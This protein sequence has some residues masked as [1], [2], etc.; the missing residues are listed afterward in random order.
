VIAP[1]FASAFFTVSYPP[2]SHRKSSTISVGEFTES[3]RFPS[4][5][6]FQ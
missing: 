1:L 2:E 6:S 4:R 5:D 3:N